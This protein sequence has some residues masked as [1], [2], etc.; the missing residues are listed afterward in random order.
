MVKIVSCG[1]HSV[2]TVKV[3][4]AFFLHNTL[5]CRLPNVNM[6]KCVTFRLGEPLEATLLQTLEIAIRTNLHPKLSVQVIIHDKDR[7]LPMLIGEKWKF[8]KKKLH[9]VLHT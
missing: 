4:F 9:V 8:F 2:K 3:F 5:I 7:F 1:R 6:G